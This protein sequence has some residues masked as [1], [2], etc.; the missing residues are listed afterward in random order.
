MFWFSVNCC[1]EL[2]LKMDVGLDAEV[3]VEG[4]RFVGRGYISGRQSCLS[5]RSAS[6]VIL[7][8]M[9]LVSYNYGKS[10]M[11]SYAVRSLMTGKSS[12]VL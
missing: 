1:G 4:E 5:I 7:S 10:L 3:D 2:G 8:I 6:P 12:R 9:V 11:S